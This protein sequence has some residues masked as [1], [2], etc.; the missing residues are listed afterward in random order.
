MQISYINKKKIIW[1]M[2]T[3]YV[4]Q[5]K[6][7]FFL[8]MQISYVI[9]RKKNIGLPPYSF[10]SSAKVF[11]RGGY[12]KRGNYRLETRMRIPLR[13]RI[14]KRVEYHVRDTSSR[15]FCAVESPLPLEESREEST[16]AS[17]RSGY[18]SWAWDG[19]NNCTSCRS[20]ISGVHFWVKLWQ[21]RVHFWVKLWQVRVHFWVNL[22]QVR[23]HFWVKFLGEKN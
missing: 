17:R 5:K 3:L 10:D 15:P 6:I 7:I 2:K 18:D 20:L 14:E 1:K 12:L 22:E 8:K 19:S 9:K 13:K 4:N 21:V 23:V 11:V 16:L